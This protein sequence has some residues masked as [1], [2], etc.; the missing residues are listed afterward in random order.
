MDG[1]I[2]GSWLMS[3]MTGVFLF[4]FFQRRLEYRQ[5]PPWLRPSQGRLVKVA[6]CKQS[7][8]S[9]KLQ[10]ERGAL[11]SRWLFF[12]VI[13]ARPLRRFSCFRLQL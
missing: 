13:V 8:G 7:L 10:G 2:H 1:I 12:V 4:M 3:R 6:T 11:V 9:F 5:A